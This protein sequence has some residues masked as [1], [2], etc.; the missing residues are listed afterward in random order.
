VRSTFHAHLAR[1]V[2][3]VHA[4]ERIEAL[5]ADPALLEPEVLA[6]P[7]V[8]A[9]EGVGACEA[10][11]GTLLHHYRAGPDGL[12]TW[13]NLVVATGQNVLAMNRAV[14][15]IADRWLDGD[16]LGPDV[17]NRIEAG[18]RAFDP[19]L[20]CATHAA[21]GRWTSVRLVGPRGEILDE[22]GSGPG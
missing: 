9:G 22:S 3:L 1:L 4:L 16:H 2:E 14:R 5:L 7:G 6:P 21:G 20:S 12:V 13:A 18:I 19:C 8:R 11:R 17:L 10:P 15:Q